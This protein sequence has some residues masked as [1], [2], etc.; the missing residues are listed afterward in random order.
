MSRPALI[1]LIRAAADPDNQTPLVLGVDDFALRKGHVYGTVL[2]GIETRRPVDMLPERSAESFRAWLDAHP[3]ME[4]ICRDRGGCYAEGAT[5]GA[6]L[7]IQVADRWQLW[8]NLAE[9]V[10]RAASRHRSCLQEPPPDPGSEAP[11]QEAATAPEAGLAARTRARRRDPRG[12]GP[13]ADHHR[14]Q[15]HFKG[16]TARRSA[17]TPP[18]RPQRS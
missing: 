16:W 17:A 18:P 8:H 9:A 7:V 12:A 13:R 15:P 6:P 10:E 11:A 3:G 4:V 5:A 14:D 2:A 1:R